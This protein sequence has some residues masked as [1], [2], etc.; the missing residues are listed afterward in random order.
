MP[1]RGSERSPLTTARGRQVIEARHARGWQGRAEISVDGHRIATWEQ[2]LWGAGGTFGLDGCRFRVHVNVIAGS[3]HLTRAGGVRVATAS[4]IGR[5]TWTIEADGTTHHFRRAAPWRRE[6]RLHE[7][8][9]TLG[10]I[11]PKGLWRGDAAGDLP[12]MPLATQVFAL[13][14]A[15]TTWNA[16]IAATG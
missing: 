4:G 9:H 14:L 13:T 6:Q 10:W 3:A 11:R 8:G 12:G 5:S 16:E 1:T 2:S 7:A 15:I